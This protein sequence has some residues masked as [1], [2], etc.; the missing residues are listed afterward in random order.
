MSQIIYKN[1]SI[2][3]S[4]FATYVLEPGIRNIGNYN[5]DGTLIVKANLQEI[6][7]YNSENSTN[8][9]GINTNINTHYGIY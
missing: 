1:N 5:N 9:N 6:I 4:N 2:V 3:N 8:L 7:F